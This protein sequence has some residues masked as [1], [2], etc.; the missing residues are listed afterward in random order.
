MEALGQ[1]RIGR[2]QQVTSIRLCTLVDSNI[3]TQKLAKGHQRY[4]KSIPDEAQQYAEENLQK[5]QNRSPRDP[6]R[7]SE[8][9]LQRSVCYKGSVFEPPEVPRID[10]GTHRDPRSSQEGPRKI[11][12]CNKNAKQALQLSRPKLSVSRQVA[13]QLWDLP[14]LEKQAIGERS[15]F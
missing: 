4:H 10:Q 14:N 6:K 12:D 9:L 13:D 1:S 11:S 7:V 5:A 8:W 3:W 15:A 2:T